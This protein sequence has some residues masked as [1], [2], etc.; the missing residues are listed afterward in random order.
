MDETGRWR[1]TPAF[2]ITFARGAG[3][4]RQH[5]MSLGGKRD[6]FTSRDLIDLGRKFGIKHDG[7][8]IIDNLRA[9]LKNWEQLAKEWRV[10]A[11]NVTAIKSLFRLK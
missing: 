7:K 3:Y 9:A 8:P 5:Q 10:P 6:G 11:K 4:T 2:D 1:L